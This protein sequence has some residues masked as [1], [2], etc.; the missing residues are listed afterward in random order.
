M[1]KAFNGMDVTLA[2]CFAHQQA[3]SDGVMGVGAATMSKSELFIMLSGIHGMC[4]SL[5]ASALVFI[6]VF[7][8]V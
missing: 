6:C 1:L 7:M 3:M 5:F 8:C 2:T 4:L